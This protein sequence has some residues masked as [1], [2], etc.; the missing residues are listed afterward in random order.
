MIERLNEGWSVSMVA[1]AFHQSETTVRKWH[2]RYREAGGAGLHDRSSR[3]KR[4]RRPVAQVRVVQIVALRRRRLTGWQI[5]KAL[6]MPRSTVAA[7]LRRVGLSRLALLEPPKPPPVRYQRE[8]AGE[9][10]HLDVKPLGKIGVIGHRI[11]GNRHYRARG[12]GYEF[13]HVAI[14]D[15]SRLAYAEVLADQKGVTAVHFF[16]RARRFFAAHGIG[17]IERV[18][19]DNGS[20]YVSRRFRRALD[21]HQ[22]RHL[23]TRPYRPET[24]GKAERFIQTMLL[25]WAYKRPYPTSKRRTAALAPWLRYYN[26]RRPHRSLGMTSPLKRLRLA[27]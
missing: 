17:R 23:R 1:A 6:R 22:T 2:T 19:T 11:H 25:G 9:L 15:A 21:R 4:F 18:M 16:E 5:A 7:V 12:V 8:H 3:P 10:V 27:A 20:C 13:V 14:G 24:N 26:E